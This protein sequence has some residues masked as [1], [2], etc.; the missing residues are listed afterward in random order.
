MA[1]ARADGETW[2]PQ[3]SQV[4]VVAKKEYMDNVR[5]RWILVLS[6]LFVALCL[7]VS[8]FGGIGGGGDI[9]LRPFD[10]TIVG[11]VS[12]V[13]SLVPILALMAGYASVA[14][15]REQGSLQLLLTMPITRLEALLG[16]F[17]GLAAVLATS[18][19][20]GLGLAGI[21]IAATAG[22]VGWENYVTFIGATL[23]LGFAFLSLSL[24]FSAFVAKRSTA[25]G[26][27][28]FVWFFFSLIWGLIFL[29]VLSAAGVSFDFTGGTLDVPEWIWAFDLINPAEATSAMIMAAFG[30]DSFGGFQ[31]TYPAWVTVMAELAAWTFVPLVIAGWR[32]RGLDL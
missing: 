2:V 5:G 11:L 20:A 8:A 30:L 15:E 13:A 12:I 6:I 17:V 26:L 10:V 24:M 31:V 1:E 22:S 19:V 32:L 4:L 3:P 14:G 23:L 7:V 18:I 27:A 29:G 25:L 21:L 28:V 9:G 16:K